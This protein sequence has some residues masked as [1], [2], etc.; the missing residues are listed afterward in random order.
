MVSVVGSRQ[1]ARSVMR[2]CWPVFSHSP[3]LGT[4]GRLPIPQPVNFLDGD[5]VY[6]GEADKV[7]RKKNFELKQD[8][9]RPSFR[10]DNIWQSRHLKN[11][12]GKLGLSRGSSGVKLGW[13]WETG[14]LSKL[15]SEGCHSRCPAK[16]VRALFPAVLATA[17]KAF[18][19]RGKCAIPEL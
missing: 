7:L 18:C 8:K 2:A 5:K 14:S 17:S 12:S 11:D 9:C 16:S 3:S 1:W 15:F 4:L 6:C 19:I 13:M 10:N